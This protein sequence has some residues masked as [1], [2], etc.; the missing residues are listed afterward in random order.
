[1]NQ[2]GSTKILI[3]TI[4]LA[5]LVA[6]AFVWYY[7]YTEPKASCSGSTCLVNTNINKNTNANTVTDSRCNWEQGACEALISPGW[8]YDSEANY[9]Y[10]ISEGASGCSDP[11]FTTQEECHSVCRKTADVS[12]WETYTNELMGYSFKYPPKTQVNHYEN[13]GSIS[14]ARVVSETNP[15][16]DSDPY[17]AGVGPG[18][19]GILVYTYQSDLESFAEDMVGGVLE[20]EPAKVVGVDGFRVQGTLDALSNRVVGSE[21]AKT[22]HY[23]INYNAATWGFQFDANVAFA[24][25]TPSYD[26]FLAILETFQFTE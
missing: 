12:S 23:Y 22:D 26:Q 18:P 10:Y 9:C 3:P 11:P 21:Y 2:K 20:A 25:Q 16:K 19:I 6:G 13:V 17:S 4:I 7:F 1:M 24:D 15:N 8:H 5:I 14:M